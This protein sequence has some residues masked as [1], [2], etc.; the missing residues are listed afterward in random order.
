[1]RPSPQE[2]VDGVRRVLKDVVGPDLSSPHARQRLDE[3]RAVL[4]QLEW[5]DVG[6][7]LAVRVARLRE[8]LVQLREA[9]VVD[10]QLDAALAQPLFA[11]YAGLDAQHRAATAA[12][13][14]VLPRLENE[15]EL[16]TVRA[17]L[18]EVLLDGGH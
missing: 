11:T 3:V 9:G 2:L 8:V 13:V 6:L 10:L 12:V 15:E 16:A 5:D 1:M 4:A 14:A 7:R 17:E 18:L